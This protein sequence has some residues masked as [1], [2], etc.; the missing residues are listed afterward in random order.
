[1][2]HLWV[3]LPFVRLLALRLEFL[4]LFRNNVLILFYC[5]IL[6]IPGLLLF[7]GGLLFAQALVMNDANLSVF[8]R[9]IAIL[10]P[11][12]AVRE[13]V[14][15]KLIR[16]NPLAFPNATL[17][18]WLTSTLACSLARV[19]RVAGHS[20]FARVVCVGVR[21]R[22]P[23]GR[24]RIVSP[25]LVGIFQHVGLAYGERLLKRDALVIGVEQTCVHRVF[26]VRAAVGKGGRNAGR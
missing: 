24:P 8:I 21:L 12:P 26:G 9:P 3:F 11:L 19:A 25:A 22:H 20:D 6:R 10:L 13:L 17:L 14:T 23:G 18:E 5:F 7:L 15:C 16:G 2:L 4:R 1:G